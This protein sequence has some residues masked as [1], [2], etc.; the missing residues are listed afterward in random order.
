MLMVGIIIGAIISSGLL[1][2]IALDA[3]REVL[4]AQIN[5]LFILMPATVFGLSFVATVGVEKK[6]SRYGKRSIMVDREDKVTLGKALQ[7]LR[8]N[9]QTGIF[10]TFLLV[11]TI[12]LFMQDT[13]LE[14]YGGEVFK[15][16]IAETTKLNAFYGTGTLLG[17]SITGFLIAPRLGKKKTIRLGCIAVALSMV[18]V[19]LAGTTANPKLLQMSLLL[20]GFASGVTTTG[21]LSLMLDLTAAE[22][23]GTFIGTWGL[24]QAMARGLATVSGGAVLNFGK[25]V[26]QTPL[27]AYGLVFATQA[28]GMILA[29]WFL[30]RVNITEFQ[31]NAKQ[32]IASIWENELD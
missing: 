22:T 21:A 32:A 17:L 30:N 7:V 19:I 31:T 20:F 23:A 24:A 14:P 15:M 18:F 11:M 5:R 28:G 1:K 2:Q 12:S 27:M 25:T 29:L 26:F 10:F 6:Y 3:P 8:A 9:R 16:T 13:V 4:Q